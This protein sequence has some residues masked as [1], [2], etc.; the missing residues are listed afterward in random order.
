MTAG[1]MVCFGPV[2]HLRAEAYR[3]IV[4]ASSAAG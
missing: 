2:N 3:Q 1:S 4:S